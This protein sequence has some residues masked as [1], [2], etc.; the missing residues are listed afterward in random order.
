[1]PEPFYVRSV[2]GTGTRGEHRSTGQ[3]NLPMEQPGPVLGEGQQRGR[4]GASHTG[5]RE[6]LT[7]QKIS[8]T[9]A[10]RTTP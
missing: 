9:D 3:P 10:R 4:R 8:R 6:V 7:E 1:M 5:G 2:R